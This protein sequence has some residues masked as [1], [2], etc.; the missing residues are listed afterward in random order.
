MLIAG[1]NQVLSVQ[2]KILFVITGSIIKYSL[3]NSC[4]GAFQTL[5][6][7]LFLVQFGESEQNLTIRFVSVNVKSEGES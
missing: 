1:I 4:L 5:I 7:K 2:N 6:L 3:K